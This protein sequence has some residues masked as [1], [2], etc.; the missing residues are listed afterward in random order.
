MLTS[1][2]A[3]GPGLPSRGGRCNRMRY[4][5]ISNDY[6]DD[7]TVMA[8]RIRVLRRTALEHGHWACIW[9]VQLRGARS[10]GKWWYINPNGERFISRAAAHESFEPTGGGSSGGPAAPKRPNGGAAPSGGP[11]QKRPRHEAGAADAPTNTTDTAA[12]AL[13][14]TPRPWIQPAA[15]VEVQMHEDGLRGS[16][17]GAKVHRVGQASCAPSAPSAP[18][19]GTLRALRA[20]RRTPALHPLHALHSAP[21]ASSAPL[22][23]IPCF[24]SAV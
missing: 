19:L 5:H 20:L 7:I 14:E 11:S 23:C 10:G 22:L 4:R 8:P 21:S 15:L 9:Q 3:S 24:R 18:G 13:D 6:N 12:D 17:Y 16:R 2:G 1:T